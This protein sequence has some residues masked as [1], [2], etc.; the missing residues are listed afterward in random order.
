[1]VK[2]DRRT[3]TRTLLGTFAKPF[4]NV[5]TKSIPNYAAYAGQF[6]TALSIPGC[7]AGAK[8]F[9]GQRKES[10]AVNLGEIFDLVNTNPLGD[11]DRGLNTIG[12]K[13]V[14]SIA[15]EIPQ[16]CLTAGNEP[17]I[18]AWTTASLRQGR[19]LNPTP[20]SNISTA[21]KEGGAWTQVSRLGMPLVNEVVIGL[22]DKDKFN[23]SE[24]K[25]DVD[26]CRQIR[27]HKLGRF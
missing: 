14:T 17:V 7:S 9:V 3:G 19:L 12:D 6:I 25:D 23:A 2:G 5:G 24:P 26:P 22:K 8:V 13:N 27:T 16:S 20:A 11:P 10:F 1:M 21:S 18:G 15:L 4:D